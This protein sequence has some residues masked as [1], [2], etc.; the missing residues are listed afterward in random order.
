MSEE[1]TVY[2]SES[3]SVLEPYPPCVPTLVGLPPT[4][5]EIPP[6]MPYRPPLTI[7]S[8]LQNAPP[9][10]LTVLEG[11]IPF[12]GMNNP[13]LY[14]DHAAEAERQIVDF[15]AAAAAVKASLPIA[16]ARDMPGATPAVSTPN[17]HTL[18][19]L[20][21]LLFADIQIN[22]LSNQVVERDIELL[23]IKLDAARARLGELDAQ[24]RVLYGKVSAAAGMS[25]LD[26]TEIALVDMQEKLVAVR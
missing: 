10:P 24:K 17:S 22:A 25:S 13:L 18:I 1:S 2:A 4:M 9:V 21:V 6:T 12:M 26:V 19:R 8:T 20:D 16:P 15:R 7:G 5:P 14:V 3:V 11:M 23:T